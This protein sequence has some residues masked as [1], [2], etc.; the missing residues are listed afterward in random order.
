ME[1]VVEFLKR[2]ADKTG[3]IREQYVEKNIPTS[4]ADLSVILFLGD[5]RSQFLM[6]SL[7]LRKNKYLIMC[8]YPGRGWLY[9]QADEF[10]SVREE[11]LENLFDNTM[12]FDNKSDKVLFYEQQLN[13]Y[14][15][16][17]KNGK[18]YGVYYKNGL[19]K[20]YFDKYKTIGYHLPAL[21]SPKIE[22][23][24]QA[25]KKIGA[26][27][28]LR[29]V[30][31]M[32]VWKQ[33]QE[34]MIKCKPEFWKTLVENLLK[35]GYVPV[36]YLDKASYDISPSFGDKCIYCMDGQ[37]GEVLGTMRACEFV[38]SVFDD[39]SRF[40]LMA[41]CPFISC[42]DRQHYIST[43]EYEL[44]D[45]CGFNVLNRYIFSFSTMIETEQYQELCE[46]ICT[47]LNST[48]PELDRDHLPSTTEIDKE[49]SYDIVR[50]RKAK[51]MGFKFLKVEKI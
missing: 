18:D 51:Q 13:R 2:A 30:K 37:I 23:S 11:S 36:I 39:I 46:G 42:T 14:F 4:F 24:K 10:W 28:F 17:V 1:N 41:R 27:I 3:F 6:S 45:L 38:L 15:S 26:K 25:V 48:M 33:G 47:K 44:N 31:N 22:F 21:P 43:K 50:K 49:L 32:K 7:L 29:P 40:A 19:N 9:P 34:Q 12:G 5:I 35:D 20:A 16:D 8:S